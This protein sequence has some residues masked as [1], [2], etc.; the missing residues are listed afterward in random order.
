MFNHLTALLFSL[1]IL[2]M[3]LAAAE[4]AQN[5]QCPICANTVDAS[6]PIFSF[7]P[8]VGPKSGEAAPVAIGFCTQAC[9]DTFAADPDAHNAKATAASCVNKVCVVCGENPVDGTVPAI[10]FKPTSGSKTEQAPPVVLIGFC[11]AKCHKA[12]AADPAAYSEKAENA[13]QKSR[14]LRVK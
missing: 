2:F 4:S 14:N 8:N 3:P 9:H 7:K 12:Y 13:W 1:G 11:T 10:A 6:V 5:S